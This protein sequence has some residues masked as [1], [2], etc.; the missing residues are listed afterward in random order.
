MYCYFAPGGAYIH[1]IVY[2]MV[3]EM[4]TIEVGNF[5]YSLF[6][7]YLDVSVMLLTAARGIY[8]LQTTTKTKL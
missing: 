7:F 2:E 8:N 4:G 6:R 3:V 1:A 5:S